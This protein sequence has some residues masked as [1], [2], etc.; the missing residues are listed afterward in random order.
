MLGGG[1]AAWARGGPATEH[2]IDVVIR[3]AD[4]DVHAGA[5]SV[6]T[7]RPHLSRLPE[8]ADVL[9][10]A[11]DLTRCGTPEEAS[12][13]AGELTAVID[14][15]VPVISVL[16]N[17][18]HHSDRPQEV[19]GVLEDAGVTVLEGEAVSVG[20]DGETVGVAGAK[21]F[22]GG[23]TVT[24]YSPVPATLEGERLEIYPFLGS[25]HLAEAIDG[26]G[27]DLALHGHA[28]NGTEYGLT[29]GGVPVRNVAQPVIRHAYRVY[30]LG[31]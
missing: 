6:G 26:A 14:A 24:H 1:L 11:G 3:P 2:N 23:F 16:G 17:H 7:L 27:A 28:H 5:D 18:D 12:V 31:T 13:L 29:P 9:I 8:L 22:G 15:G 21:G 4:G 25:S 20:V 30:C 10:M 19:A